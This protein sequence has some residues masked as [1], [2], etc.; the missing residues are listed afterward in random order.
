MV[1]LEN[2]TLAVKQAIDLRGAGNAPRSDR[3]VQLYG[4]VA[5]TLQPE[6]SQLAAQPVAN[7]PRKE[8]R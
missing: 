6:A 3:V 4:N 8:G 1:L 2:I 7:K 5:A